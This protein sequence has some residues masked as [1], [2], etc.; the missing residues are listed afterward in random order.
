[1]LFMWE[2][3]SYYNLYGKIKQRIFYRYACKM[4]FVWEHFSRYQAKNLMFFVYEIWLWDDL[5]QIKLRFH[6]G[7]FIRTV[8]LLDIPQKCNLCKNTL[9]GITQNRSIKFNTSHEIGF[10][11]YLSQF[12][13]WFYQG[14]FIRNLDFL[15][16]FI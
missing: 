1:M 4:Q 5:P 2:Q 13:L 7:L 16:I 8:N 11:D 14:F 3:F 12:K 10:W 15:Q 9:H 6:L